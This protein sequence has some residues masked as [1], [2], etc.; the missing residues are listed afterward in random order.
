MFFLENESPTLIISQ[1]HHPSKEIKPKRIK[2]NQSREICDKTKE[3]KNL[4]QNHKYRNTVNKKALSIIGDSI[5]NGI[6]QQNL[7]NGSFKVRVKNHPGATT[8]DICG[9]LKPEIR[10]KP[11]IVIIHAGTNDLTNNSKSLENCKRMADSVR[12]KLPNC[13]LTISNVIT[14]KV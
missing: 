7:S 12:S 2:E 13:R 5:L 1:L 4:D 11:E 6:D 10:K 14:R 9:H 8:E 3:L